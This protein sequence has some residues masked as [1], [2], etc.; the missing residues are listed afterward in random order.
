MSLAQILDTGYVAQ[1]TVACL[2]SASA[3][4]DLQS[5]TL[6]DVQ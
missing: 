3:S 5:M 4:I 2:K 1:N 6:V